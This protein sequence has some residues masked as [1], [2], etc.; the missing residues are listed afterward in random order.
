MMTWNSQGVHE[1][2][3]KAKAKAKTTSLPHLHVDTLHVHCRCHSHGHRSNAI[4]TTAA[5][6]VTKTTCC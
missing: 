1:E 3:T 6:E 5:R 4:V 2:I